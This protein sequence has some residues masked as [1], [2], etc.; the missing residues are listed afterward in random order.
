MIRNRLLVCVVVGL[1]AAP[2]LAQDKKAGGKKGEPDMAAMMQ[3]W[4]KYA[5]PGEAHQALKQLAGSWTCSVKMWMAPGAPAQESPA[6]EDAKMIMG[7]RYVLE[8]V[9]GSFGG[10]PFEGSG[11]MG[12]DNLKKKY[13]GA[14]IDNMGTGIMTSEGT[15]DAAKKTFT[16]ESQG[17][18]PMTGKATKSRA[19]LRIESDAK[20]VHEMYQKG[21]GG[22]EFKAMEITYTR[23][24]V[25]AK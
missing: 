25:A 3:A 10:M 24:G 18:D 7:D 6:T 4:Q 8:T 23:K 20:L 15:Y 17:M 14:W 19:I 1:W 12:Y 16:M 11:V 9:K 13:V 22:K 21:P 5:T 2:A